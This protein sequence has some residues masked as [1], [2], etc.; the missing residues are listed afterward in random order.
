MSALCINYF[1]LAGEQGQGNHVE[2]GDPGRVSDQPQE[3]H[4]RH[5]DGL[6]G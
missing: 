4:P 6:R 3:V 2:R 5:Q 1:P